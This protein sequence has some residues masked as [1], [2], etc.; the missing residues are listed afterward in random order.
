MTPSLKGEKKGFRSVL[1]GSR[2]I[3]VEDSHQ[4]VVDRRLKRPVQASHDLNLPHK[5]RRPS[6]LPMRQE[7]ERRRSMGSSPV[8]IGG[9]D[10]R[11]LFFVG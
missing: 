5:G 10:G 4:D 6:S 7:I 11:D 2:R 9:G 3:A 8:V 1:R